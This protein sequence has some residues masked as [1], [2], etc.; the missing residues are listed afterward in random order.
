MSWKPR[1]ALLLATTLAM[2][3]LAGATRAEPVQGA[4]QVT[5]ELQAWRV[6]ADASGRETFVDS[7][8][9][10][11][12]E[13]LE[14]RLTYHN[15]TS[16][17]VRNLQ[18]TLPVPAGTLYLDRSA[19]PGQCQASLDGSKYQA[20]PLMRDQKQPDGRVVRVAVPVAEY[21]YLRWAVPELKA[22]ERATLVARVRVQGGAAP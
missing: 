6:K 17:A 22:G 21:R 11:P 18:A 20:V 5:S 2:L 19:R 14:Y 8:K 10:G 4:A 1:P 15:Q 16:S 3:V 9:A 12:G 13:I 7:K